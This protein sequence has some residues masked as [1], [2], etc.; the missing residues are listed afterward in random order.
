MGLLSERLFSMNDGAFRRFFIRF[1]TEGRG[2][3][4]RL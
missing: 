3:F 1:G 2:A 4:V